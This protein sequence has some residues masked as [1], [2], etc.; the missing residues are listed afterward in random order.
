MY[1]ALALLYILFELIVH[2]K[3]YWF[4]SELKNIFQRVPNREPV[5]DLSK[6]SGL[7]SMKST[8]TSSDYQGV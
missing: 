7:D 3:K 2:S 6:I 8:K 4:L 5:L 1:F